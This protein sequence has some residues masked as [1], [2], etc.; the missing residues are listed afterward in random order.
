MKD[1][2]TEDIRNVVLIGHGGTGKTTLAE[3]MLFASGAI[4]RLGRVE[5]GTT[6][7]D[8]DPDEIK[9]TISINLALLPCE[10]ENK[11]INVVDA[12]GYADFTGE[13]KAA[14]HAADAA[15]VLVD[16]SAGVEVGTEH[17]WAFADEASLPRAVLIDRMDRENADFAQALSQVQSFFGKKCVALQIPVGAQSSFSGV[18]DV[19]AM[20]AYSGEKGTEG[21]VPDSLSDQ[22]ARHR[23]QLVEAVAE[24]DDELLT[25][26]LDGTE[27]TAEELTRGLRTGIASGAVVPVLVAAAAKNI[28]TAQ[29]LDV[30]A[31]D[32]P[33]PKDRPPIKAKNASTGQ[34]EDVNAD[35]AGPLAALVFKTTADP[36]VGK[37]TYLRVYSGVLK[38]DSSAWNSNKAAAER[39]GQLF[40][41]RGKAQEPVPQL[42]AGD[43]GALAKLAETSTGDTLA[44]KERPLILPPITFPAPAYSAAVHPKTK[45]DLD[46]MG[47]A[48]NR[49]I[50]E[51]PTLRVRRDADTNET[52]LSGLGEPHLEV[53]VEKIQRKF[54]VGLELTTPKVPYKETITAPSTSEYTH[55][56]QT[57]GHGQYA[58]V[59]IKLEPLPRGS[60]FQFEDKVVGG[61]VPKTYIPAV[62][63]GVSEA[64]R[65]GV[66]ARYPLVDVKVTL[67]D[68]KEHPVD[69]SEM[70]FKLAGS[71]ALRQGVNQGKPILV[72][73]IVNL[74]VTVPEANTGDAMGDLNSKRAK[75]LGISP[76]DGYSVIEAQVPLAEVQ[77]YATDLRSIT[78]GRGHYA[79]EFDHYE[80]VPA[81]LAQKIIDKAK[82]DA[83]AS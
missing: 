6:T 80:E 49:I 28:G 3:A 25:K 19:L 24:T 76:Q 8:F 56:K 2:K 62:E 82:E 16:A 47:N 45:A 60:G 55:K 74:R 51:D 39:I 75:V 34:E 50:E 10:W 17:C 48:L 66:I 31:N 43:I 69:S 33:S 4:N 11:K 52:I 65:E 32:F 12:P 81:H 5:E 7:S 63:K 13:M 20:K 59:A 15:V 18:V 83:K 38:G 73:P 36:Y 29:L 79:L 23:E 40:V 53:T 64:M 9:R 27:L 71:A 54:G 72:E 37:L 44:T 67:Y 42:V 70:A 14:I 77:H 35:P 46:K 78:Q 1:Y 22:A 41:V 21:A 26:Y 30:L 61:A 57:G 68:G 58:R